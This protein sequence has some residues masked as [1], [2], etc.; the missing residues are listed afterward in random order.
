MSDQK[1]AEGQH[2]AVT[3]NGDPDDPYTGARGMVAEAFKE[4]S[5]WSYLVYLDVA[6]NDKL[7][8]L[9]REGELKAV[10]T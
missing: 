4:R 6:V 9:F 3:D 7:R 1:F 5:G 10:P 8:V 2:V